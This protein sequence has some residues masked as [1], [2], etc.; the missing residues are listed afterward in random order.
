[1]EVSK[2]AGEAALASTELEKC[3]K[4]LMDKIP[5]LKKVHVQYA[6]TS[7]EMDVFSKSDL[8]TM[9][10][11]TRTQYEKLAAK[12]M[13]N[14]EEWYKSLFTMLT[15]STAK[16]TYVQLLKAKTLESEA[17]WGMNKALGKQLQELE[18]K[19][20]SDVQEEQIEVE[21]TI[22]AAKAEEAKDEPASEGEAE[23]E[24]K[25]KE[26]AEEEEGEEEEEG[27]KEEF[28]DAKE[29]EGGEGEGEDAQEAEDEK[30]HEAASTCFPLAP[31]IQAFALAATFCLR[32]CW[33]E[34][35]LRLKPSVFT[36]ARAFSLVC[37]SRSTTPILI[38][39]YQ[40]HCE[41]RTG[42][43]ANERSEKVFP[44]QLTSRGGTAV[45]QLAI[46]AQ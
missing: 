40:E 42:S 2:D 25:E 27:D 43:L 10:K 5:F 12:N 31:G 37:S 13:Q 45:S 24:E 1:M 8:S 39:I 14:A 3:I 28:E 15:E 29:E 38:R 11:D 19:Q 32:S 16:S 23:E 21:E 22:E 36:P 26:E 18:D 7:M 46:K 33:L 4:S 30:K 34:F 44:L 6:Q 41:W 9:L 35:S 20:N 17:S